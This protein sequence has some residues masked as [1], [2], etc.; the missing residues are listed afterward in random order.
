MQVIYGPG[1]A[2]NILL[3]AQKRLIRP[4]YAQTQGFPYAAYLDPSLR[5]GDGSL[6]VP[7]S[8]ATPITG[9][10]Y[11]ATVFTYEGSIVPGTVVARVPGTENIV[12]HNG[13]A[14]TRPWGLLDQWIGGAFDGVGKMNE[15]SAWMGIDSTYV[16]LAPAW[17]DSGLPAKIAASAPGV[18]V[19]LYGGTDGRLSLQVADGGTAAN[20]SI[21][22]AR[23]IERVSAAQLSIQLLV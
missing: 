4:Q 20:G 21:A 10:T 1:N 6:D 19:L 15:V 11:S 18:D 14:A 17:N 9:Y 5:N 7:Q 2:S 3:T 16:M 23:V 8:G 22:V 12:V 13:A